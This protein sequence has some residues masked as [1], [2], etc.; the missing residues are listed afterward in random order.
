ML[1]DICKKREA[2][3]YFKQIIN[4]K[5]MQAHLCGECAQTHGY[6]EILGPLT[7]NFHN[8]LGSFLE[9]PTLTYKNEDNV[10]CP[11]CGQNFSNIVKNGQVGCAQCYDVFCDKIMPSIRKIHGDTSHVGKIPHCAGSKAMIKSELA[12]LNEALKKAIETQEFEKAAEL[13]DKIRDIE[14]GA[15]SE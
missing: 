8:L 3:S 2:T 1:C 11:N 9:V 7:F 14:G 6:S 13:R 10:Y 4:G 15:D 5:V 12:R